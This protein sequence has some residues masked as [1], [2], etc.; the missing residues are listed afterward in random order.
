MGHRNSEFS[1][2]HLIGNRAHKQNMSR[3]ERTGT[4]EQVRKVTQRAVAEEEFR[5]DRVY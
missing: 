1:F 4:V 2:L 5:C 3:G